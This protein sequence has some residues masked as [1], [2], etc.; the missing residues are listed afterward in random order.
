M[1]VQGWGFASLCCLFRTRENIP[2]KQRPELPATGKWLEKLHFMV[3]MTSHLNMLNKSLQ[4]QGNTALQMLEAILSFE[5]SWLYSPEMNSEAR[6]LTSPPWESSKKPFT[7]THSMVIIYKVRSLICKPHLGSDLASSER[8]KWH[9]PR[10]TPEDWPVLVEHIPRSKSSWPWNGR[11]MGV[12]I[13]KSDSQ[14]WRRHSPE[15][16]ACPKPQMERNWKPPNTRETCVW[17]MECS[18]WQL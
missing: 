15:S 5:P 8:E 12:Q 18:S 7:I 2:E 17:N 16:P 14:A 4:G 9:F 11:F 3:D 10:H 13:Q 1:A 6:S